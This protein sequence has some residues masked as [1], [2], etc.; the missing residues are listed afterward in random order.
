MLKQAR[1]PWPRVFAE[2]VAIVVSILLAFGIEAWY[3]DRQDHAQANESLAA[4]EAELR[5]NLNEIE[6]EIAFR[7]ALVASAERLYVLSTSKEPA[8]GKEL[9]KLIC[10]LT[11]GG[12]ADVSTG[13]LSSILQSGVLTSIEAGELQRSLAALPGLYEQTAISE[14]NSSAFTNDELV[15]FLN[16]RGSLNQ[17]FNA[18][19]LSG[20]PGGVGE[21]AS[22][23]RFPTTAPRDHSTLLQSDEFLGYIALS[24]GNQLNVML[25]Y[26]RLK[27]AIRV[28]LDLIDTRLRTA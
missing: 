20:R 17:I 28:L 5:Q 16:R 25:Y 21:M 12:H 22:D 13:A 1:V 10:D 6:I 14:E 9:D 15:Y 26:D 24:R 19:E 3:S 23:Y 27:T 2:G 11:W 7:R 8:P 18:G 4:L